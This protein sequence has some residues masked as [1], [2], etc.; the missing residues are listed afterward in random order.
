MRTDIKFKCPN[1]QEIIWVH[2][3]KNRWCE[4]FRGECWQCGYHFMLKD[5]MFDIIQPDSPFFELIYKYHPA[6]KALKEK[7]KRAF[8]EEQRKAKLE[9]KYDMDKNMKPWVRADIKKRV[10]QER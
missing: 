3:G 1:C 4:W 5:Y 6:K 9:E 8:E 7:K 2:H 10:L